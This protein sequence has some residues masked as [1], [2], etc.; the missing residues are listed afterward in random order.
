FYTAIQYNPKDLAEALKKNGGYIPG[1]R[2]GQQTEEFIE[3][4]LNRVTLSGAIFLAFIAIAPDLIVG[5]WDL[6]KY[7]SLAYMF[8]GTSLLIIVGVALETLKQIESQLVMRHYE[9]FMDKNKK[10]APVRGR[11]MR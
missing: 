3:K 8:G 5:L 9:G 10:S 4:I 6:Q 1:I 2:P 11:V 7:R